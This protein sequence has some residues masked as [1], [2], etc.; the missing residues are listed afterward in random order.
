MDAESLLDRIQKKT[1]LKGKQS[2]TTEVLQNIPPIPP[3]AP[4]AP[5]APIP[6]IPA[7]PPVTPIPSIASI[8]SEIALNNPVVQNP[9]FPPSPPTPPTPPTPPMPKTP[10]MIRLPAEKQP[11]VKMPSPPKK[12]DPSIDPPL[13]K[14]PS[15]PEAVVPPIQPSPE[16]SLTIQ[17]SSST[18][19]TSSVTLEP[20]T[21]SSSS[22]SSA[23]VTTS[24]GPIPSA[25]IL[26]TEPPNGGNLGAPTPQ[27]SLAPNS[28][29]SSSNESISTSPKE[30]QITTESLIIS[31]F[32]GLILLAICVLM[33][34]YQRKKRSTV[35]P[36]SRTLPPR[37][38][39]QIDKI[40]QSLVENKDIPL[41]QSARD[42][43][44]SF[45]GNESRYTLSTGIESTYSNQRRNSYYT[46][47]NTDDNTDSRLYSYSTGVSS[48]LYD[49]HTQRQEVIIYMQY[50]ETSRTRET[51]IRPGNGFI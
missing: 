29:Q 10:P 12:A 34:R 1:Q 16:L 51:I 9:Q 42:S 28:G 2:D 37:P 38:N 23:S 4:I 41:N 3:I 24:D 6:A 35:S 25:S 40:S 33:Y 11:I 17:P 27:P 13:P 19:P 22:T 48:E 5:I 32:S 31:I 43:L 39:E 15:P 21:S 30:S 20:T 50:P 46:S 8:L 14:F 44:S 36:I 26:P 18:N 47:S 49:G 7:M 45:G